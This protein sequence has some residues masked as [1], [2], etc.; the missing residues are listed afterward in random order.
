MTLDELLP[1]E[2]LDFPTP[3]GKR[4]R[5]FSSGGLRLGVFCWLLFEDLFG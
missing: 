3:P 2:G 5:G 4:L 1:C